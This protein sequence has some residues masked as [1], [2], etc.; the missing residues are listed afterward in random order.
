MIV[1]KKLLLVEFLIS[2][3]FPML[4]AVGMGYLWH[5]DIV[6]GHEFFAMSCTGLLVHLIAK[7]A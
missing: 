3:L 7:E 5:A 6:D 4:V 2:P 1:D